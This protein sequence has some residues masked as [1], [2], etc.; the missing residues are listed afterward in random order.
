MKTFLLILL[1]V[2]VTAISIGQSLVGPPLTFHP[3]RKVGGKY[4]DLTP[5]YSWI[6]SKKQ[7]EHGPFPT[8]FTGW[9]GADMGFS[10]GFV[11]SYQVIEVLDEG[12]L[13]QKVDFNSYQS[14]TR[15]RDPFFLKNYPEQKTV[16]D[17]SEISFLALRTG[18]YKY[19]DTQ[20]AARTVPLYDYGIPLSV[21]EMNA[22][23]HPPLTPEQQASQTK[24]TQARIAANQQ[25][26]LKFYQPKAE[27]GDG[28]A[29][30]RLGDD[31][32]TG[33]W[34]KGRHGGHRVRPP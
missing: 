25:S 3:Y 29:Q 12:L 22:V 27:A 11:T 5:L 7:K 32:D 14:D 31:A 18:S 15:Y 17:H 33:D 20:G 6:S 24:T 2:L 1:M 4:Y 26:T 10:D 16:A 13:V 28:F 34:R 8:A 30:M 9:I 19:T 21:Q 23:L